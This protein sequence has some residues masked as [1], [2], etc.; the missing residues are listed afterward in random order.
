M[1]TRLNVTIP[2][3]SSLAG[4]SP[5]AERTTYYVDST[6]VVTGEPRVSKRFYNATGSPLV[7]GGVYL[8]A[9][10]GDEET[11]PALIALAA[12]TVNRQ[13]AVA[14]EAIATASWGE[15]FTEGWCN[16]L[17]HGTTD[18]AKDDYL[19]IAAATGTNSFVGEGAATLSTK[20]FAIA[21]EPFTTDATTALK[22]VK[23]LG[24]FADP[25]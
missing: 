20:S 23:L 11:G 17:V 14:A 16:A 7:L 13:I 9:E 15:A 18:I 4:D 3:R 5:E 10:D 12:G 24:V 21:A 25:D 1:P 2:A 6:G 8:V 22:K 19:K